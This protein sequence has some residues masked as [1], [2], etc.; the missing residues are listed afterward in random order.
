M[1]KK[2]GKKKHI[3][4]TI[5]YQVPYKHYSRTYIGEMKR[6]LKVRLGECKQAVRRGDPSN[7]LLFNETQHEIDWDDAR[8]KSTTPNY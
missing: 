3:F 8:V 2:K 1:K 7:A 5:V 6:T 4:S